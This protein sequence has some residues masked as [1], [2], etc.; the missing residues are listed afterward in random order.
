MRCA[1]ILPTIWILFAST[2]VV[3]QSYKEIETAYP[4]LI[5]TTVTDNSGYIYQEADLASAI[6]GKY[7]N[8]RAIIAYRK[9]GDFYAVANQ[10]KGHLGYM[11]VANLDLAETS[12][13][14]LKPVFNVKLKNP[15]IGLLTSLAA[16]GAGNIYAGEYAMGITLFIGSVGSYIV[17]YYKSA[18]TRDF[19]C[20]ESVCHVTQDRKALKTGAGVALGIWGFGVLST[21]LAI[22]RKNNQNKTNLTVVPVSTQGKPGL[23]MQ[24]QW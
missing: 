6:V 22:R 13:A 20:F 17:G 3:A 16:P 11:H 7:S 2:V 23:L 10:Q 8:G 4:Q 9:E 12:N 24:L 15:R 19:A 18:Q 5:A 21:H 1:L 14:A